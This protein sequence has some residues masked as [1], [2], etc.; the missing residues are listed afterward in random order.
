MATTTTSSG[1]VGEVLTL[2]EEH[3]GESLTKLALRRIGRDYMTLAALTILL[4][5]GV[6]AVSAPLITRALDVD[7]KDTDPINK[8][9]DIGTDGH[10][11]GTDHLGR[12]HLARLLY[13]GRVSLTVGLIAAVGSALIG[14]SIGLL[15]G[16]Y[17]GGPFGFID[18]AIMWFVT[19]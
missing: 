10:P 12:D 17:Q 11:L 15:A 9:L 14:V 6:M 8:Y 3:L 18:D 16:Y 19:T 5:L 1:A 7:F 13:G 2:K 4:L